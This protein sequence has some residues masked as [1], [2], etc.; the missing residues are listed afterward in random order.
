MR[1]GL[2]DYR[3]RWGRL[4]QIHVASGA[5]LAPGAQGARVEALRVRLGLSAGG[6]YDAKLAARVADFQTAHG[7]PATGRADASTVRALNRGAAGDAALAVANLERARALPAHLGRRFILVDVAAQRLWLYEDGV[8]T[9]TMKV[10]V[11]EPAH[12]T[13]AMAGTMR[14][15]VFNPYW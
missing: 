2:A 10:V 3:A 7:L 1:A 9:T 13:P 11:G 15:A 14:Y 6:V 8:A 12:A 4:P 5:T